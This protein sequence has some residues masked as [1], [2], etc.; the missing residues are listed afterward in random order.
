M[1]LKSLL[2][3]A[4]LIMSIGTKVSGNIAKTQAMFIYNFL[5][6]IKWPEGNTQNTFTIGVYGNSQ[7]YEQLQ[8]FTKDRKIGTKLIVIKKVKTAEEA[9]NCQLIFVPNTNSKKISEL[10][11]YMGNK[12]CL[13]VSEKQGMNANGSTIEFVIQDNK[14]KFKINEERA[15]Q[16]NLVFSKAL[17][18][19]AV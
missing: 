14:L 2:I 3:A 18:D 17:I 11:N 4:L 6:H 13:I 19:M 12:A 15:K 10:K 7:T 8:I 9:S 16:Q 1:K 5:R